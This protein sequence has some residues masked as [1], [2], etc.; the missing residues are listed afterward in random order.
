M[1]L[2]VGNIQLIDRINRL[3]NGITRLIHGIT[4]LSNGWEARL[5]PPGRRP[6]AA[7]ALGPRPR[8]LA[9]K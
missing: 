1:A 5:A 4:R 2:I 9:I 8:P 7:A 6:P 3:I